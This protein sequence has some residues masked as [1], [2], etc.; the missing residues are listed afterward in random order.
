MCGILGYFFK[1]N[2]AFDQVQLINDL[3]TL[4]K[5]GPDYQD[6]KIE[7]V[8][9]NKLFLGH[10]RLSILELSNLGNQPYF[11]Y[12]NILIFYTKFI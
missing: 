2:N 11:D 6:F 9:D 4:K 12:N 8:N 5:R 3:N 1:Q 7:K 10:T